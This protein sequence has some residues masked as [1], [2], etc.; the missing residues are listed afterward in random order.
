MSKKANIS[1]MGEM[2]LARRL[3]PVVVLINMYKNRYRIFQILYFPWLEGV[4]M[5][6][7]MIHWVF[8]SI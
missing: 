3:D 7:W 1:S 8:G 6:S 2:V 5:D 4:V